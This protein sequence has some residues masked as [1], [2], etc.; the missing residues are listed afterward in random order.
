[1]SRRRLCGS[2]YTTFTGEGDSEVI[3]AYVTM[4]GGKQTSGIRPEFAGITLDFILSSYIVD[5]KGM[6]VIVEEEY[7]H[8]KHTQEA[9]DNE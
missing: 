3:A 1:M 6:E 9:Y 8:V 7:G 5:I 2:Q 4:Q